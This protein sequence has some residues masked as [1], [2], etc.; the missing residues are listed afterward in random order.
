LKILDELKEADQF[1]SWLYKIALNKLRLHHRKEQVQKTAE[2]SAVNKGGARESLDVISETVGRELKEIVL[3]AMERLKAEHRAVI[4]MRCYRQM[5]YSTIGKSMGCSEFA[6]KM[7]FCRAKRSLKRQLARDGFGKGSLL[8]ALIIF[9]QMTSRSKAAS[10]SVPAGTLKAGTAAWVAG[11]LASKS[12]I[13]TVAAAV[14]G[15]GA[16]VVSSSRMEEGAE[17]VQALPGAYVGGTVDREV[18]QYLYFYPDGADGP[19]M[20]RAE[21]ENEGR[22]EECIFLQN[23]EGNYVYDARDKKV[24]MVNHRQYNR[25]GSVWRLP[26]DEPGTY[27][28]S[29][30]LMMID[31]RAGGERRVYEAEYPHALKD[32]YFRYSRPAGTKVIDRRDAMHKRGWTYFKVG[33]QVDGERVSGGGRIPF[34][35][36]ESREHGAWRLVTGE[37]Y[38]EWMSAGCSSAKETKNPRPLSKKGIVR[39]KEI[40]VSG[41]IETECQA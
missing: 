2:V 12:A 27:R 18:K 16:L 29:A 1:W 28:D 3:G 4:T 33:G 8:M 25:D 24:Y 39:R 19:V 20:V 22:R 26:T 7:L 9:G 37:W 38:S 35:Y 10:I 31:E 32:E 21:G 14:V 13:V 34:V 5:Q 15:A 23:A 36:G 6:A 30:D 17:G 41:Q 11:L 40:R